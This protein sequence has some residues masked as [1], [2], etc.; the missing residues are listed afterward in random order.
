MMKKRVESRERERERERARFR[1]IT[2][3]MMSWLFMRLWVILSSRAERKVL[4]VVSRFM[5]RTIS[6]QGRGIDLRF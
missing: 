5:T 4:S 6:R 1:E 2:L 3:Y